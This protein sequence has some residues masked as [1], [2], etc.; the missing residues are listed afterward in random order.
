V[1]PLPETDRPLKIL[2]LGCGTGLELQFLFERL[3]NAEVTCIDL[4]GQM[5]A[6]LSEHYQGYASQLE[7]I[8][9]SYLTW[10]YPD[11]RYDYVISVNTMHHLEQAEK[12]KLYRKIRYSLKPAGMYIES[13]FMVDRAIM[14]QYQAR[15]KRI[16]NDLPVHASGHYHIDIPFTVDLQKSLLHQGDLVK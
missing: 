6:L 5:L 7:I 8:R 10:E 16:I 15:F 13:D 4:S 2:D 9:D 1:A 11:S 3:P 14:E 12:V